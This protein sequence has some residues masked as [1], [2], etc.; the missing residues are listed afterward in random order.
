MSV[1]SLRTTPLEDALV[2]VSL[3]P[4]QFCDARVLGRFRSLRFAATESVMEHL[5][6][7]GLA[8]CESIDSP[9]WD[10]CR[11]EVLALLDFVEPSVEFGLLQPLT[12]YLDW[13]RVRCSPRAIRPEQ[14]SRVLELLADFYLHALEAPH[15]AQVADLLGA[16][17]AV[18]SSTSHRLDDSSDRLADGWPEASDFYAALVAADQPEAMAMMHGRLSA[19][20]GLVEFGLH[21]VQPA[22]QAIGRRWL[23]GTLTVAEEHQAA[24]IAR[25]VMAAGMGRSAAR[26]ANGRSV[27]LA[28]VEGNDHDL[29][30]QMV[31]DA[32]RLSGW[33][34]H[35]LGA[36]VP[37]P[38]LIEYALR[39]GPQ[40]LGLSVAFSHQLRLVRSVVSGLRTAAGERMPR[41]LAGGLAAARHE[42]LVRS[43]GADAVARNSGEAVAIASRMLQ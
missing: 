42:R 39:V 15:G 26:P 8:R 35:C 27:L 17:H 3:L 6:A 30:L 10:S 32:F 5:A 24:A 11:Q 33:R 19:D 29:G 2:S 22:M 36:N 34:V 4:S 25:T 38:D 14:V 21:V 13:S 12:D 23:A 43:L 31:A 28:C 1:R 20:H 40:V 41:V 7:T 18:F 37:T 9:P 16:V